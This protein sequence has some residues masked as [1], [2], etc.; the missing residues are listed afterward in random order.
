MNPL[1]ESEQ[2]VEMDSVS[3][4]VP[5]VRGK[6]ISTFLNLD[7]SHQGGVAAVLKQQGVVS[8]ALLAPSHSSLSW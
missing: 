3:K 1:W 5:F 6:W 7:I 2:G 8:L 4:L